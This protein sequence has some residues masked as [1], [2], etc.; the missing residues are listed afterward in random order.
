VV[1]TG[2]VHAKIAQLADN[3]FI[4]D[5][6]EGKMKVEKSAVSMEMTMVA[7]PKAKAE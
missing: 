6:E 1:T 5:L 4:L 3:H 2:G 7:Y